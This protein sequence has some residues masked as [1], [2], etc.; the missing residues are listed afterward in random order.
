MAGYPTQTQ[1]VEM[2][3]SRLKSLAAVTSAT[4]AITVMVTGAPVSQAAGKTITV[5][6][7][8]DA[9][10]F[11]TA[12]ADA[13]SAFQ[14]A[15]P[16]YKVDVQ[17]QTWGDHLK[18]LDASL[19]A[20]QTPD[21]VE[22]GN[23][24]VLK[25]SANGALAN[26]SGQKHKFYNSANWLKGL[27]EAGSYN[28]KL[29][30]VPYYA[31]ARA[32]LYRPSMFAAAGISLPLKSYAD[33]LAAG[34][35]LMDKYGSNSN[36]SALYLPGKYWYAAM[37]LVYDAGG[38]I[39]LQSG[40]KWVGNL[41]SAS[42]IAGLNRFKELSDSLSRADKSG[43]EA[44]QWDVFNGGNVAMSYSNG[45]ESCCIP[46]VGKDWAFMPMPSVRSGKVSPSFLG[47]S[48]LGVPIFS[49]NAAAAAAWIRYYTNTTQMATIAESGAIPNNTRQLK[50]ISGAAAPVAQ[51]AKISW[52]VPAAIH[53]VDV[54]NANVLQTMLSDIA[55][56][57]QSVVAAA[58][59][60][61]AQIN[62]ILNQ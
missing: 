50:L 16:N 17:W 43:T 49:K 48:N 12:V 30:A 35:K 33:F 62:T 19:V 14:A 57:K 37:S 41:S 42:S 6:L 32:V 23:T 13:N 25:Y 44:S 10:N 2:R 28:G 39:A 3:I 45:W 61:D 9:Q 46:K 1:E 47:G 34:K 11:G 7:M 24:E 26:L 40:G 56:G 54:E 60:A 27:T 52:F 8:P 51:A 53:W 59:A 29:Y 5:W 18:K 38:S 58:T 55:T 31:G 4:L 22:F 20:K 36:F 21:V 15:F